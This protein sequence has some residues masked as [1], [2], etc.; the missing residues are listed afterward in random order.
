M[1]CLCC[2]TAPSTCDPNPC[3]VH[4][5]CFQISPPTGLTVHCSCE[6]RWTGKYCDVNMDGMYDL[7]W[8][9]NS[10][11]EM[12]GV[13]YYLVSCSDGYCLSGGTCQMNGN[14]AWCICPSW[15]TG[16]RCEILINALT[17]TTTMSSS[18]IVP[19][20]WFSCL[21]VYYI[22]IFHLQA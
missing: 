13:W 6:E 3:G 12:M 22:E 2:L 17:T 1:L 19:G 16:Q 10:V 11:Q 5:S 4:G 21:Y 7:M 14:V 8:C 18:T 20:N 15:Y 9:L